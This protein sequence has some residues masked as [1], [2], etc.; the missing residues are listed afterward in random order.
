MSSELLVANE[1][2]KQ[3]GGNKFRCLTG[4]SNLIGTETSL[5]FKII[6]NEK[7]ITH[8]RITLN[9][10]D[11]YDIKYFRCWRN[12]TTTISESNGVYCDQLTNDFEINTSLYTSL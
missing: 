5:S 11:T 2:L 10:S 9:D 4:C 12:K 3:L 7:K 1:I 8:V 6:R